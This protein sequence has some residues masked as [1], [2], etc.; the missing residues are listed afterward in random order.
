VLLL[1]HSSMTIS[2]ALFQIFEKSLPRH[3][4]R[5]HAIWSAILLKSIWTNMV[6]GITISLLLFLSFSFFVS[7]YLSILLW[8]YFCHFHWSHSLEK[9]LQVLSNMKDSSKTIVF[10]NTI[11]CA[12]STDHFLKEQGKSTSNYHGLILPEVRSCLLPFIGDFFLLLLLFF[13]LFSFLFSFLFFSFSSFSSYFSFFFLAFL[14]I[15]SLVSMFVL[16]V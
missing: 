2:P 3:C 7:F 12:R 5:C 11:A 8:S 15:L 10:C 4:I 9:L 1:R 13:S 6:R 14:F 16:R